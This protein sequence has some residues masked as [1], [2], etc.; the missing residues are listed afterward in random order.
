VKKWSQLIFIKSV[1]QDPVYSRGQGKIRA[2]EKTKATS[3][4]FVIDIFSMKAIG[5]FSS[6]PGDYHKTMNSPRIEVRAARFSL[7]L[8]SSFGARV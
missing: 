8:S 6:L 2:L 7:S 1:E 4:I 3:L 5:H